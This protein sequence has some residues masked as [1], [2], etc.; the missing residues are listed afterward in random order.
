MVGWFDPGPL[1][2]TGI[3]VVISTLFGRH[4]D[5]RLLEALAAGSSDE[6]YDY[7]KLGESPREAGC[8]RRS[9]GPL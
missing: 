8:L 2:A 7:T 5:Y 3:S 6:S 1:F 4:S 9:G